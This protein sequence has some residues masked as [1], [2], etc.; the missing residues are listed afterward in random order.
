VSDTEG[1]SVELTIDNIAMGGDGVGRLEDGR[2]C[3]VDEGFPGEKVRATITDDKKSF[4]RASVTDILSSEFDDDVL[5]PVA[6]R[7]GGCRFWRAPYDKEVEWKFDAAVSAMNRLAGS[8]DWPE[9]KRVPADKFVDYRSRAELRLGDDGAIGYFEK[10]SNQLVPIDQCPI[11][12]PELDH[13]LEDIGRLGARYGAESAFAEWDEVREH[14]VVEFRIDA[15]IDPDVQLQAMEK[16]LC[17]SANI[18]SVVL[19]P[20]GKRLVVFG[21]GM[22]LRQIYLGDDRRVVSEEMNAQFT[23]AYRE[24]NERLVDEVRSFVNVSG[25]RRVIDLFGGTGNL[26]L[27]LWAGGAELVI[28]DSAG[29]AVDAAKRTVKRLQRETEANPRAPRML[30]VNLHRPT[31]RVAELIDWSN[32]ILLDPPRGGV[33]KSLRKMIAESSADDI[34]YVSC[35]PPAMARDV[36][37]WVAKG[38]AVRA[39]SLLDLFP[40]TPHCEAVC[41]LQRAPASQVKDGAL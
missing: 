12:R 1:Q 20:K 29:Y 6:D 15:T 35:D 4:A 16:G 10:G 14:V 2:V 13:A 8:V 33:S 34:V 17:E 39:V 23:Q 31:R 30:E 3:F 37:S 32:T 11:L 27:G 40:R 19:R 36:E 24:M 7:C 18:G 22:V 21:D 26:S 5:C 25:S 41:W 9:P 28:V 38:W